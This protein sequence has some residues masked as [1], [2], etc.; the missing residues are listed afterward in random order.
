MFFILS[1]TVA[2]LA[3][4]FTVVI[5]LLM[6][7]AFWK[8]PRWKKRFFWSGMGLLF[9]FSND[10]IANE[11]M[12][13]WE[14][15]TTAYKDMRPHQLGIVLTGATIPSLTP[16]DRVYFARGADRVTHTVQLYKM[17]L[18]KKILVSGGTGTLKDV[19]EPEADKFKNAMVMMGIPEEDIF[20]E[21]QTR[22][23]YE[24]AVVVRKMLDSLQFRAEDCLLITSAFH[25]RRS[26]ACYRKAN[27]N[28]EPFTTDFYAH[29]RFFY[30]DGLLIP[31]IDALMLW[32]KL[33]KEWLG[34][35]AYKVAGY[36]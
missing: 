27:L 7:S 24:S 20:I 4:P 35:A 1:K 9:F 15:K 29:P 16:T 23:T 3:M 5:V 8:N 10:F 17:G 32:H 18:I 19:E 13:A 2:F 21:N 22:N 31:S 33:F 30:P 34:M 11:V 6:M 14:I 36:I 25:M 28:I 12:R 26:L